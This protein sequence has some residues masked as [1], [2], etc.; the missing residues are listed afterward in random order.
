MDPN[1]IVDLISKG[2]EFSDMI[3]YVPPSQN[4]F[5]GLSVYTTNENEKYH[6]WQSMVQRFIKTYYSSD[7]DDLKDATKKLSPENHQK[8]LGIL[9]AIQKMPFEPVKQS[10]SQNSTSNNISIITSQNLNNQI[11]TNLLVDAFKSELSGKEL[12]AIKEILRDLDKDPEKTKTKLIEKLKS[13][14]S[15]VLSNIA[16]N[17][18]SNPSIFGGLF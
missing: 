13:F 11:N 5:R 7:L 15:D 4:H 18:I 16:A 17:I 14:G 6:E 10:T 8:I 2:E 1:L 12:N 3:T 9:K